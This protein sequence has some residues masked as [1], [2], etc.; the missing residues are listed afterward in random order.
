VAESLLDFCKE[1]ALI[2]GLYRNYDCEVGFSSL[3]E[4][5]CQF[6]AQSAVPT[7]PPVPTTLHVL[8]FE[9][10]LAVLESIAVRF[11]V[12]A[13]PERKDDP[14]GSDE[15]GEMLI[16]SP[17]E[18]TRLAKQRQKKMKLR[19]AKD[20]FNAEGKKSFGFLQGLKLLADPLTPE[21]V[22]SF[23]ANTPGLDKT[24]I[25]EILGG[26]D[27]LSVKVLSHFCSTFDFEKLVVIGQSGEGQV[28]KTICHEMI[29]HIAT[30]HSM[31]Q[32]LQLI[33]RTSHH[34]LSSLVR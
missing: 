13:D 26:S 4:D 9:S 27:D 1:P 25:G 33:T 18:E 10:V 20:R 19:L 15:E 28:R 5:L 8:S 23:F 7:D 32:L 14:E 22:V 34:M 12:E 6:L 2:V 31:T 29:R 30:Q 24:R 17:E 11:C 3:F 21:S 16:L